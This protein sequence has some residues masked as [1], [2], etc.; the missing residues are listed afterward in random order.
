MEGWK[1]GR[2]EDW[3]MENGNM[4]GWNVMMNDSYREG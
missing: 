3:K 4:E 2:L 1:D